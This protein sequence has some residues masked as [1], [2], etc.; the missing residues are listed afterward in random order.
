MFHKGILAY[1]KQLHM[2][3]RVFKFK[4]LSFQKVSNDN[5]ILGKAEENPFNNYISFIYSIEDLQPNRNNG[6]LFANAIKSDE[7]IG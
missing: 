6:I 4:T 7:Y 1:N 2:L 5:G 3:Y